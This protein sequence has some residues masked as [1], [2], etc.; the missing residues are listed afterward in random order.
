MRHLALFT[1]FGFEDPVTHEAEFI[2]QLVQR[3]NPAIT[4]ERFQELVSRLRERRIL[5]GKRTLFIV[6]K[7]LHIHL[8]INYWNSYGRGFSFIDFFSTV[9]SQLQN[10]FLQSFIYGH[11][12]P[13][14]RDVITNILSLDGPFSDRAFLTGA[15]GTRFINYLSEAD[16]RNPGFSRADVW[17]VDKRRSFGFKADDKISSG[18]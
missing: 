5:Q 3:V 1:K 9:P 11:A 2:S 4:W 12:S 14:A 17:W 16:P 6:P 13:V 7:A 8:W 10:W 18:H 15:P